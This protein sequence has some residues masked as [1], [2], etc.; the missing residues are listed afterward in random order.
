M[1]GDVHIWLKQ[2]YRAVD[3]DDFKKNSA[4]GRNEVLFAF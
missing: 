3:D 2:E 4:W 1:Y